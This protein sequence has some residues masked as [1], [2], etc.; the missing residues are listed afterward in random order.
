MSAKQHVVQPSLPTAAQKAAAACERREAL[1]CPSIS[2]C[3]TPSVLRSFLS[4]WWEQK[5]YHRACLLFCL[6][7][8]R[9]VH[10]LWIYPSA[11]HEEFRLK[12]KEVKQMQ[13]SRAW[14]TAMSSFGRAGPKKPRC[15]VTKGRTWCKFGL[16]E[17]PVFSPSWWQ[18]QSGP[19][20]GGGAALSSL[21]WLHGRK[22][23]VLTL[24][25]P[26]VVFFWPCGI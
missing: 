7:H 11:T 24:H 5:Q 23:W 22:W 4:F 3:S 14:A 21:W 26:T 15:P 2:C 25:S 18:W 16:I 13:P 9:S 17:S 19:P 8:Y 6:W 1:Q 12:C 20:G 10:L